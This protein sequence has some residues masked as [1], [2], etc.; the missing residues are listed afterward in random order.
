M[1]V[2]YQRA[3]DSSLCMFGQLKVLVKKI[4]VSTVLVEICDSQ[5]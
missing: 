4:V 1:D 5:L 3:T 2:C